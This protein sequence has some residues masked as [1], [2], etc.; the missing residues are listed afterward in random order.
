MQDSS[1][2]Y[3]KYAR[4]GAYLLRRS[5][6]FSAVC[7]LAIRTQTSV[8]HIRIFR[9]PA[10]RLYIDAPEEN[11][12]TFQSMR[13]LLDFY[14]TEN[15]KIYSLKADGSRGDSFF[16]KSEFG[17]QDLSRISPPTNSYQVRLPV[18]QNPGNSV[19]LNSG[20]AVFSNLWSLCITA[21]KWSVRAAGKWAE[22]PLCQTT[23]AMPKFYLGV[24]FYFSKFEKFH[25]EF[26]FQKNFSEYRKYW[27]MDFTRRIIIF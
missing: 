1:F 15:R 9:D 26:L 10:G 24:K 16:M 19:P 13:E 8:L 22:I 23:S 27:K 7:T 6:Y 4:I 25:E 11:R 12:I 20:Q 18:V 21:R 17:L 5:S 3:L 2:E 14:S